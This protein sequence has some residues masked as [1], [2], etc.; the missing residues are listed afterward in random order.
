[1]VRGL[2]LGS[3]LKRVRALEEYPKL[4]GSPLW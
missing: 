1:M 2:M 3:L 4:W